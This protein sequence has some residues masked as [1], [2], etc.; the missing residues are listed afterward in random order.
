VSP[1]SPPTL[2]AYVA[3]CPGETD[4]EDED[5]EGVASVKSS[6]VPLRLTVCVLPA[7]PLLLSVMVRVP[8][9]GPPARGVNVT[10]MAQELLAATLPPQLVVWLKSSL[11]KMLLMV[12]AALPVLLSVTVCALD[13]VPTSWPVNIS[14]AG[15]RVAAGFVVFKSTE[16]VPF[17]WHVGSF[18]Q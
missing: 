4:C 2:K 7:A 6:P 3:V 8:V 5:P 18:P 1:P 14:V 9:S 10:S 12:S 13:A 16:I 11:M 17:D 15:E